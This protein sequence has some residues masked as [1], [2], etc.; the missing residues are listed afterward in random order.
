MMIVNTTSLLTRPYHFSRAL[1]LNAYDN[2]C[3]ELVAHGAPAGR[4]VAPQRASA[5]A[6]RASAAA[7][8][9]AQG[10]RAIAEL[11]VLDQVTDAELAD[12]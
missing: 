5:L 11:E 3:N 1:D 9:A 8:I 7:A 10:P 2:D 4:E 6:I 12:R